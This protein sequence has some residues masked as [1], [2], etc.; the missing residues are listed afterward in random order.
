VRQVDYG[1]LSGLWWRP[2]APGSAALAIATA[3]IGGRSASDTVEVRG[4]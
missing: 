2:A 4:V 3:F 1:A